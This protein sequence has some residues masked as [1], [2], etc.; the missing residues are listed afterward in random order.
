MLMWMAGNWWKFRYIDHHITLS[1]RTQSD[2]FLQFSRDQTYL[3]MDLRYS[4]VVQCL[5]SIYEALGLISSMARKKKVT[6][7]LLEAWIAGSHSIIFGSVDSRICVSNAFLDDPATFSLGATL[8]ESHSSSITLVMTLACHLCMLCLPHEV[9]VLWPNLA[10]SPAKPLIL[11][12]YYWFSKY[13]AGAICTCG[14][15]RPYLLISVSEL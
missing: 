1:G 4:S 11:S 13:P 12:L 14:L 2:A 5:S 10:S 6:W 9:L 7:G 15:L 8:W 3:K